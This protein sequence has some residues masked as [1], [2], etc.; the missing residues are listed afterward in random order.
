[1][2]DRKTLLTNIVCAY[3]G[4]IYADNEVDNWICFVCRKQSGYMRSLAMSCG[5]GINRWIVHTPPVHLHCDIESYPTLSAQL[6]IERLAFI[7][8]NYEK[9][10]SPIFIRPR[11]E[12]K[13]I[14]I[15]ANRHGRNEL[16]NWTI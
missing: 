15:F 9:A 4:A 13:I 11:L 2:A 8:M 7:C 6:T 5:Q 16:P 12:E 10:Q 14:V 3:A 1:M